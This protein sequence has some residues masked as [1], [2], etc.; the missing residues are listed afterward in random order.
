M[1]ALKAAFGEL[2]QHMLDSARVMPEAA[3]RA[4]FEFLYPTL[5]LA[6]GQALNEGARHED[7][8]RQKL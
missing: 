1:L 3:L 8:R 2:G 5:A 7:T 4:G 6:L